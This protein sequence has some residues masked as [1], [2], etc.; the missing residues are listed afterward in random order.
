MKQIITLLRRYRRINLWSLA[1]I[2]PLTMVFAIT[3]GA[4]RGYH[5]IYQDVG[6]SDVLAISEGNVACPY[7]SLVPEDCRSSLLQ[8]PHVVD[9][10]GEVR[11]RHAYGKDKNLTLTA[12]DPAKLST[13]KDLGIDNKVLADFAKTPN[14]ALVGRKIAGFFGWEPGQVVTASG[15]VFKVAGVFEQPLSVYES[16]VILHKA[17]LQEITSKEGYVTSMLVKTD[18]DKTASID[19][20]IRDIEAVFKDHPS[21][22]VCRPED[23]LWLA[24]KASQGNLGDIILVLGIAIGFLKLILHVNNA[25]LGLKRKR[26]TFAELKERFGSDRSITKWMCSEAAVVSAAGGIAGA[27]IAWLVTLNRP[28]VG[29][30]M[31]H[32]PIFIDAAV[33]G[34]VCI[35]SLLS[36]VLAA[37]A[38]L[39]VSA[40]RKASN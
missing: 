9:V 13:F 12:M 23:E 8:V 19:G 28:Y 20:L 16:M 3:L 33:V 24:I 15:L 31:F 17:Y 22:I 25:L 10:A 40:G 27:L 18:L 21:T 35:V 7:I 14:G 38:V 36:G 37:I 29:S 26:P 32:P 34:I 1:T 2:V 6:G 30:D 11:Q 5:K 4:G 39:A